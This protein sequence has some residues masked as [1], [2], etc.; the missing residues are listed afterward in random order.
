MPQV[1]PQGPLEWDVPLFRMAVAQFEQALPYADVA[2]TIAERL[3]YPERAVMFSVPVHLDD[4][5]FAVF[6][7]YRVQRSPKAPTARPRSRRMR[8]SPS[9]ASPSFRTSSR[10]RAA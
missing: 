10:T 2:D 8:S 5:G 9:A 4:G 7:A 3:R 6:P 1:T